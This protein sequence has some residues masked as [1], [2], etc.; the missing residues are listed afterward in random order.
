MA[1]NPMTGE[2]EQEMIADPS[3]PAASN[4]LGFDPGEAMRNYLAGAGSDATL[5]ALLGA[6]SAARPQL[7]ALGLQDIGQYA[8]GTAAFDP[9]AF[10][11][12]R[13]DIANNYNTDPGYA[14]MYGSLEQ[15]AKAAAEAAGVIHA[16][17]RHGRH[18]PW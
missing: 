17:F 16:A 18:C 15:Y 14:Q 3:K 10:L 8:G 1:F 9:R 4:V 2:Y 5:K 11:E 7:G 12:A 6:E 13:P